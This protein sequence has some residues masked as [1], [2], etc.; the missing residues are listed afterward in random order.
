MML[1]AKLGLQLA[2]MPFRG[3]ADVARRELGGKEY[4]LPSLRLAIGAHLYPRKALTPTF[5]SFGARLSCWCSS[6]EVRSHCCFRINRQG[7]CLR[8]QACLLRYARRP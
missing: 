1:V 6:Q 4:A 8:Q 2:L 5:S 3:L 7:V